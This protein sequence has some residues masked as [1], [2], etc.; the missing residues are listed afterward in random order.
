[1]AKFTFNL[2]GVLRQRKH[3]EQEKQRALAGKL[4][5]V[6]ELQN[7]LKQMQQTVDTSTQD[8]RENRLVGRLDMSFL[9]AHRRFMAAMQRQGMAIAQ[10]IALAQRAA[11]EARA[12]LIEAAKGRKAIE[13][14]REKQFERWRA[15]QARREQAQLDEI[16]MQL[17]Y[18]DL[19]EGAESA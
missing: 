4:A 15:E 18:H 12:E 11:D 14:L 16:G 3:V 1:M 13:K 9:A 6:V 10:K 7:T 5:V 19:A 8:L 2:E 17:A